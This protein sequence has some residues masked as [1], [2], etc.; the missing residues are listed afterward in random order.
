[1]TA[2]IRATVRLARG[3]ARSRSSRRSTWL[4]LTSAALVTALSI[5]LTSL[6]LSGRQTADRD[7]G[8]FGAS[9]GYGT[10]QLRPGDGA[11]LDDLRQRLAAGGFADAVV[12]LSATDVQLPGSPARNV[13][14]VENAWTTEPFPARY[15]LLDGRW[16]DSPG[17]VVVTEPGDVV[18]APGGTLDVL[19]GRVALRV[20]GTADDR[21]A[22]TSNLLAAPGTWAGWDPGRLAGFSALGAQPYVLWNGRDA[23]AVTAAVAASV[24]RAATEAGN[25]RPLASDPGHA[26]SS[27]LLRSSL[28]ARSPRSW[29]DKLPAGYTIP[30][31][32]LPIVG[33]W[34]VY[35][36]NVRRWRTTADRLRTAGVPVGTATVSL[37]GAAAYRCLV[38]VLAGVLAGSALGGAARGVLG[39]LRHRPT[40]PF[41][42][43]TQVAARQILLVL[44]GLGVVA[45]A[46]L[47]QT[48]GRPGIRR[49]RLWHDA[50][51]LAAV[52]VV[53]GL[54]VFHTQVSTPVRS[55][56]AGAMTL[57]AALLAMP[58]VVRLAA[59]AATG[60]GLCG[61][62]LSRLAGAHLSSYAAVA[63]V[64][65]VVLGP[66]AGYL[67][68]V[69]TQSSAVAE[70]RAADV[71]PGQVLIGDRADET[72]APSAQVVAAAGL[73]GRTP[74]ELRHA[75][76]DR[77]GRAVTLLVVA[78]RSAVE[79]LI[80]HSLM[81]DQRA[82]LEA[83]GVL[84]WADAPPMSGATVVKVA[85][86]GWRAGT[87]G[88]LLTAAA[89]RHR[90]AVT[91]AGPLLYSGVGPA[92]ARRAQEAVGHAGL[93]AR[94]VRIHVEPAPVRPPAAVVTVL[95][96]MLILTVLASAL[97]G[98]AHRRIMHPHTRR[99]VMN[100]IP[101]VWL[102]RA[103]LVQLAVVLTVSIT[104]AAPVA[105]IPAAL[106]A[107]NSS[108]YTF[109]VPW[110]FLAAMCASAVAAVLLAGWRPSGEEAYPNRRR[111]RGWRLRRRT[112]TSRARRRRAG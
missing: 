3:L 49:T 84:G 67:L 61:R 10:V 96:G 11:F 97:A 60:A 110:S 65:T 28:E 15:R 18:D 99:L 44:A 78:D 66:A 50:R 107:L 108:A 21:Y 43:V 92:E 59:A 89:R 42:D 74:V 24:R 75:A 7:L 16:P 47:W 51:Q 98:T 41:P 33:V 77:R 37:I 25:R 32:L 4:L 70:Q 106:L 17:E 64:L 46:L 22:D 39:H 85:A 71:L 48:H 5:V 58:D 57:A 81:P 19:G 56:V 52:V 93:D 90:F 9:A 83:D 27:V 100:G 82:T 76:A 35:A 26:A 30:S 86:C 34:L 102:R 29:I 38:A 8:R 40:G 109:A 45:V 23:S 69:Q 72:A 53:G 12:A 2:A 55:M 36:M 14:L 105:V 101:G 1:M 95:G 94:T 104:V 54:I 80:G 68:L 111:R 63:G 88:V 62:V 87:D 112:A 20:V 31:Y 73:S 79:S 13:T 91:G 103:T 6:T